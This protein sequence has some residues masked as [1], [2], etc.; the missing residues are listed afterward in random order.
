MTRPKNILKNYFA[1]VKSAHFVESPHS[2]GK[3][4]FFV[5]ARD[6]VSALNELHKI[7]QKTRELDVKRKVLRPRLRPTEC[8]IVSLFKKYE[9]SHHRT[10]EAYVDIPASPNP[11]LNNKNP[12]GAENLTF[13]LTEGDMVIPVAN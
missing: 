1:E 6:P 3:R 13:G 9:D 5:R 2:L 7:L 10:V 11:D 8:T 12:A 4:Q